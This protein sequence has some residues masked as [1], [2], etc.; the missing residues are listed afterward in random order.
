M[1]ANV[2]AVLTAPDVGGRTSEPFRFV[3][4]DGA[5][6]QVRDL[7]ATRGD[8]VFETMGVGAGR[9]QAVDAH[10]ARLA[11]SAA[12][13]ELPEPDEAAWRAATVAVA[14]RLAEHAEAFVKLVYTRGVEGTGRPTGWVLGSPSPDHAA[15]R[16]TGID[17]VVLDRGLAHDSAAEL[18]WLLQGAKTLSYAVNMAALREAKRRGADD[19]L[20]VSSDG[21]LLEGP[22]SNLLL[23]RGDRLLTPA[24]S[25][26][27][28]A[29]T[30]QAEA[31]E[32]GRAQGLTVAYEVLTRE[33]LDEAD[34][35]WLLSSVRN[36]APVRAV[37]GVARPVDAEF[38]ARLNAHLLAR[39]A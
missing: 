25:L 18:P 2:L 34:A 9:A 14:E 17:V 19:A 33:A 21:F 37:D 3:D 15:A 11:R 20:F 39:R 6:L 24:T 35:L 28:L 4:P 16:T 12:M 10:L 29:G 27:I 30:T 38:T 1:P 22:T 23:R 32:F 36:A 13:L 26:G 7:A 31:F 8:G 5:V